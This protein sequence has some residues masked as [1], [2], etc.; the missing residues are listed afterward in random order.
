MIQI[1]VGRCLILL[2]KT[3]QQTQQNY[4]RFLMTKED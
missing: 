2:K 1:K 4:F 3:Q